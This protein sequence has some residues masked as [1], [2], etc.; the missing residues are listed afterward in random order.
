MRLQFITSQVNPHLTKPFS[1]CLPRRVH[2]KMLKRLT[3]SKTRKLLPKSRRQHLP[4]TCDRNQLNQLFKFAGRHP[5]PCHFP[6]LWP[7]FRLLHALLLALE[8]P[9]LIQSVELTFVSGARYSA[10]QEI[11]MPVTVGLSSSWS[12]QD[13]RRSLTVHATARR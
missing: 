5:L 10:L 2:P 13:G 1:T 4:S 11:S 12:L 7:P 6:C 3:Y 9:W 8:K